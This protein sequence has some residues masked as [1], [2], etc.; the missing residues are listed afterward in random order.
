MQ[1]RRV[2]V[3]PSLLWVGLLVSSLGVLFL[4]I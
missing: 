2:R 1:N 3:V 4:A